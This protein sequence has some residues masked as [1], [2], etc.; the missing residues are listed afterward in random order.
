M[1]DLIKQVATSLGIQAEVV[2][3]NL[4]KLQDILQTPALWKSTFSINDPS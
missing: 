3:D 2:Q 1:Q 4:Y